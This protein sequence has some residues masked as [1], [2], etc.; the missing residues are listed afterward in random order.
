MIVD[1]N[2]IKTLF[3]FMFF[4]ANYLFS[5]RV[6]EKTNLWKAYAHFGYIMQHRN[7]MGH[8]VNGHVYGAELNYTIPSYGINC[9]ECENNFPEKGIGLYWFNLGNPEQL[10][11][12]FGLSPHFEIPLNK[13][14]SN[15]RSY[16]R[17]SLGVAYVT[18]YFDPLNNHQ[19]NVMS[20]PINGFVNVKWLMKYQLSKK[21]RL[22]Y[23]V[24]LSHASNG[25]TRVGTL[26]L[27]LT[28]NHVP[29]SAVIQDFVTCIDSTT[30]R[31]SK[32]EFYLNAAYGYTAIYPVGSGNFLSQTYV[33]GYYRNLR[34]THKFGAG[35]DIFYNEANRITVFNEDSVK[36]SVAEN[37]Q[38]GLKIGWAYNIGN[39]SL[40]LEM[41][42]YIKSRYKGDGLFYHRVGVRYYFKNNF[43]ASMTLKSHW[44]RADYFEYGFGYRFPVK[45]NKS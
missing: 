18:K 16:L 12:L 33:L 37:T 38:L 1:K 10:G 34:N 41:G 13:R 35:L 30:Y 43:F 25:K 31:K 9:Y 20:T 4:F 29:K 23:G 42:C 27:A 32:N 36:I 28:F 40:P 44:A 22:D 21:L 8:L 6:K 19:N 3:L 11:N 14:Q 45:K 39:I 15:F 7:S 24:S 26:N 5:Q 2:C 17:L